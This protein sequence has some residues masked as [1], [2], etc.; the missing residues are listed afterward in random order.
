VTVINGASFEP[1]MDGIQELRHRHGPSSH[2]TDWAE[3][4]K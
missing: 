3:S 1:D 2:L 4:N